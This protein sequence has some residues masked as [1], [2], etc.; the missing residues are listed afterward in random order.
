MGLDVSIVGHGSWCVH[1][2]TWLLMCPW[3]PGFL[4]WLRNNALISFGL[5][6]LL[7][8]RNFLGIL[9]W[10]IWKSTR[11][12][13][14]QGLSIVHVIGYLYLRWPQAKLKPESTANFVIDLTKVMA[15]DSDHRRN[16]LFHRLPWLLIT[17]CHKFLLLD[18][19]VVKWHYCSSLGKWLSGKIP[20]NCINASFW[21]ISPTSKRSSFLVWPH[22]ILTL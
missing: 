6:H 13:V 14:H 19:F 22:V 21:E 12:V 15:V 3:L 16:T 5:H 18:C 20:E 11:F 7:M 4:H 17:N 9:F 1:S 10:W 8:N 2:C